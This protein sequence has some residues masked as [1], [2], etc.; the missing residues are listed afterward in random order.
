MAVVV[1]SVSVL[2]VPSAFQHEL[3]YLEATVTVGVF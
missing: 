2:V 1:I 3:I